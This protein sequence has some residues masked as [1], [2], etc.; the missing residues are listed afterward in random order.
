MLLCTRRHN[1]G[2]DLGG[3]P[4]L[5]KNFGVEEHRTVAHVGLVRVDILR[6]VRLVPVPG[7]FHVT[8]E[9]E[10]IGRAPRRGIERRR[11][12]LGALLPGFLR[13]I[14]NL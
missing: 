12:L 6:Q 4:A 3:F 2:T 7:F 9:D 14:L 10:D 13:P 1:E 11:E 5:L 8:A